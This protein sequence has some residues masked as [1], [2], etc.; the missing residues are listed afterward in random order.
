MLN[1]MN[2]LLAENL[3]AFFFLVDC[4]VDCHSYPISVSLSD[5]IRVLINGRLNRLIYPNFSSNLRFHIVFETT[6][7]PALNVL[8][9]DQSAS[10]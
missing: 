6:S 2:F 5:A 9:I 10:S 7:A 3:L 4:I 8:L 1:L